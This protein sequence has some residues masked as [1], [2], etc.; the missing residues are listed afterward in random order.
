MEWRVPSQT[1]WSAIS[2]AVRTPSR[3]DRDLVEP[4]ASTGLVVLEGSHDF[5]SETLLAYEVGYR[6]QL[7]SRLST[8]VSTSITIRTMSAAPLRAPI[9]RFPGCLFPW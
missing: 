2:R 4:E 1:L 8:S 9:L 3:I 5:K 6:A 7:G